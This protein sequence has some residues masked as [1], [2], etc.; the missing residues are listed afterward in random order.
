VSEG[1]TCEVMRQRQ[2]Q[3]ESR[4]YTCAEST[5]SVALMPGKDLPIGWLAN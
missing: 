3:Q 2:L 4:H 1:S 5:V